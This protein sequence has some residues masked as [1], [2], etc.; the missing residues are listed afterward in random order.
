MTT[1]IKH[2][3]FV[4][5][6]LM[7]QDVEKSADFYGELFGWTTHELDMGDDG[8]Y[9]M[10]LSNDT[11]IGGMVKFEMDNVPPHWMPYIAVDDVESVVATFENKGGSVCMPP[12]D[13]PNVGRFSI[14]HDP[15][16]GVISTIK[17]STSDG[18]APL[19][20]EAGRF[21]WCE[22]LAKNSSEA[23]EFYKELFHWECEEMKLENDSYWVQKL[24]G[25][26]QAGVMNMP[27]GVELEHAAWVVFVSVDDVDGAA[28]KAQSLGA[29]VQVRPTDIPGVG[30]FASLKDPNGAVFNVFKGAPGCDQS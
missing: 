9:T 15:Q 21:C 23:N 5:H 14:V 12:R 29:T 10:L 30:R 16:G 27:P 24:D 13:I 4:W 25:C 28:K 18:G 19:S 26:P 22:L 8:I 1:A 7:T 3:Q 11:P 20:S 17:F 6:D 2:G